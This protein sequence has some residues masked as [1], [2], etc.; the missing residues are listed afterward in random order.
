MKN[1]VIE[2]D[3]I[4]V[5]ENNLYTDPANIYIEGWINWDLLNEFLTDVESYLCYLGKDLKVGEMKTVR[6]E[7]WEDSDD[8][9]T[10][11]DYKE[12]PTDVEA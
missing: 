3:L 4:K 2:F 11:L 1:T 6:C 10:W 7:I 8:D 9:R 12:L 5:G